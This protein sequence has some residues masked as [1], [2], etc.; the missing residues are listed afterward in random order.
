MKTFKLTLFFSLLLFGWQT[1]FAVKTAPA[2]PNLNADSYYLIDFQSQRVLAEKN[3]DK[4]VEPASITKLM[5]AYIVDIAMADGDISLQDEVLISKKAWLMKGS[6][7][8]IEVGKKVSVE[9]LL[10]G[11]IIQSGNDAAIAL[12][13]HV[14]GSESAFVQ[15][16]NQQAKTLGMSNT[17]FENVTGWPGENHYSSARDIAILSRAIIRDFPQT[18][19]LY[20]E[21][22]YTFNNIRQIN[23]NRLIWRDDSVD[24]LKTGHTESAGYC[25]VASAKRKDMRLIAVVLGASSDEKRTRYSQALLNYGFR[26]YETF[27]LYQDDEVLKT[28]RVWFGDREEVAMS[29]ENNIFVTIPRGNYKNLDASMDIDNQIEAPIAVGQ[30]LGRITIKLGDQLLASQ[31]VVATHSINDGGLFQKTVDSIK[32]FF[33]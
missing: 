7:M 32:L 23:R 31:A 1:V 16:M 24:G 25:L 26:F 6:K 12:A 5:T 15:Y 9:D 3:P 30:E 20:K 13:E 8:F 27:Q 28:A 10:K 17:N 11:M 4:H 29:V 22:E 21:K 18:Y 33:Q 14:A 19:K 2:A